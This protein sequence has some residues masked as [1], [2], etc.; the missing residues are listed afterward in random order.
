MLELIKDPGFSYGTTQTSCET[1]PV[2]CRGGT[3]N[4]EGVCANLNELKE[5]E[6]EDST[7]LRREH[8]RT[9]AASKH[10]G[11]STCLDVLAVQRIPFPHE[12]MLPCS[13]AAVLCCEQLCTENRWSIARVRYKSVSTGFLPRNCKARVEL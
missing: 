11:A 13:S 6:E 3:Q 8:T 2:G 5:E 10:G 9:A 1:T 12:R 7:S 4:F